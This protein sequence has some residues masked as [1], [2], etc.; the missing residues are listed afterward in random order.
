MWLFP[1]SSILIRYSLQG[2]Y[3]GVPYDY[4]TKSQAKLATFSYLVWSL[5]GIFVTQILIAAD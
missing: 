5:L 2:V 1:L 4:A 3:A